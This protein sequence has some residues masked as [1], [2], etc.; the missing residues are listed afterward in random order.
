ER[1]EGG[2]DAAGLDAEQRLG[3]AGRGDGQDGAARRGRGAGGGGGG[4]GDFACRVAVVVETEGGDQACEIGQADDRIARVGHGEGEGEGRGFGRFGQRLDVE[5]GGG[6]V[7]GGQVEHE[8]R[9][10]G[11]GAL[12]DAGIRRGAAEQQQAV[13]SRGEEGGRSGLSGALGDGADPGVGGV[14]EGRRAGAGGEAREGGGGGIVPAGRD[15]H[16]ARRRVRVGARPHLPHPHAMP[17]RDLA[18]GT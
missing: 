1:R 9:R 14:G 18:H 4:A 7:K 15:R 17:C 13:Q 2:G 6:I 5:P 8:A 3:G 16:Q 10:L 11:G 12:P